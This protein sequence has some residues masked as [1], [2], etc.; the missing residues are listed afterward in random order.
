M[1]AAVA[2]L[3]GILG[4]AVASSPEKAPDT[5]KIVSLTGRTGA[6]H[7]CPVAPWLLVSSAHVYDV[8]PND[9]NFPLISYR[10]Q[11]PYWAGGTT[12]IWVSWEEDLAFAV[13]TS[14]FPSWYA[15]ASKEPQPG[16]RVWWVGYNF[17]NPKLAFDRKVFSETVVRSQAGTL[18][19]NG[20]AIPGS[21]GSCVLNAGGQVV[22]ILMATTDMENGEPIT[23]VVGLYPPWFRMP[24]EGVSRAKALARQ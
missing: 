3:A 10:G 4:L 7:G 2:V 11:S 20:R 5:S 21:S 1:K 23:L 6:A 12:G 15:V 18:I 9:P 22:G 16:D 14:D 24:D 13:P 17:K 8:Q 19:L